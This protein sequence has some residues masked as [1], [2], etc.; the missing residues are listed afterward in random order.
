MRFGMVRAVAF[1][2]AL[3]AP[4]AAIAQMVPPGMVS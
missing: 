1:L 4:V 2:I 3:L